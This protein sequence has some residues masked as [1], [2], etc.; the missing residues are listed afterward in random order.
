MV[1]EA[2]KILVVHSLHEIRDRIASQLEKKG[3][4]V[5]V[6]ANGLDGLFAGYYEKFALIISAMNL[7][8]ITGFEMVRTLQTH[9]SNNGAPTIF[10]GTGHEGAEIVAIS[11]KLNAIIMPLDAI[12]NSISKVDESATFDD[13]LSWVRIDSRPQ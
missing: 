6:A 2:K 10:I 8:K 3:Y 13:L 4:H 11:A 1:T 7:P 5:T 12:N 9:S